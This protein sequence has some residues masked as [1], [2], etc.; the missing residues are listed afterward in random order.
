MA[1]SSSSSTSSSSSPSSPSPLFD[2]RGLRVLVTGAGSAHG[3]GF[4]T[5]R[6]LQAMGAAVVLSGHSGRVMERAT[7][8]GVPA[9]AGDLTDPEFVRSLVAFAVG[10]LGGL[11]AV[12][13]NA[14]M[15]SMA[16]PA[17]PDGS[18][19]SFRA[20]ME[21]NLDTAFLVTSEALPELRRGGRGRVVNV[22]STT[23]PVMAMRGEA[24]YA[25]AKAGLM[26]LT[27]GMALDEARSGVTVNAVAPGWI[28]T[29]SQTTHESKQGEATPMGRSG[30][31]E[32]IAATICF[33]VSPGASYLTGQ[34]LVVD[35]G[36][37]IAEERA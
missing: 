2:L 27:R 28:A 5:A 22:A 16:D 37:S 24:A 20:T 35:G 34:L 4:A 12:V 10:E 21:R 1:E 31:P 29:E 36:N 25:A 6:A 8:L 26:G 17:D 33:L 23:G 30:R 3:I 15:T 19:K 14:G 13:N 7:E 11:D 32:E 18:Y 9:R